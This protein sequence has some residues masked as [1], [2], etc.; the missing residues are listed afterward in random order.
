MHKQPQLV[1]H[2]DEGSSL[3]DA[4]AY[5]SEAGAIVFAQP[6]NNGAATCGYLKAP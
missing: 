1:V 2:T 4:A 6:W 3:P 5:L